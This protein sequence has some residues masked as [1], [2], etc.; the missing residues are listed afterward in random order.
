MFTALLLE[1]PVI[2]PLLLLLLLLRVLMTAISS[3]TQHHPPL[4]RFLVPLRTWIEWF[5][6]PL[7]CYKSCLR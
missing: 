6:C 5:D 2:L 3:T 1:L 7:R 4:Q